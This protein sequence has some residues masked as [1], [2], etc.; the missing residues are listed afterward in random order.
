V[1]TEQGREQLRQASSIHLS[2]RKNPAIKDKLKSICIL[3]GDSKID[4][5][6]DEGIIKLPGGVPE[7]HV[8]NYVRSEIQTLS[9]KLAV[10]LHLSTE[11]DDSVR[12]IVEE[13]SLSNRDPHLLFN[14][15]GQR[16][17]GIP[18]F[19]NRPD[20][21]V[22]F[23]LWPKNEHTN[24]PIGAAISNRTPSDNEESYRSNPA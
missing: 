17:S 7:S 8:F 22:F 12:K 6:K 5:N 19:L 14:Q 20:F 23:A 16:A 10:A 3:D 2:H 18:S 1:T 9:M 13:I 21:G 24:W 15:V 4:E 11:K